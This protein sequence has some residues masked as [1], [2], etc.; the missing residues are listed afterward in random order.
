MDFASNL[1]RTD[2]HARLTQWI[3]KPP[4]VNDSAKWLLIDAGLLEQDGFIRLMKP[5]ENTH[6]HNVFKK[7]RFEV[8]GS[9]APHL[10]QIGQ[11]D[12]H[13]QSAFL[14][15]LLILCNGIPALAAMDACEGV[16]SLS[17]CLS[18]FAQ[19]FTPDN[20]E[21]YC[22]L[23]DTRI[24]PALLQVMDDEQRVKIGQNILQWQV[25][26]RLGTLEALLPNIKAQHKDETPFKKF[27]SG[28]SFTLSDKQFATLM[29]KSEPDTVFQSLLKD[30]P[31]LV[32]AADRGLFHQRL[33]TITERA[34]QRG[35]E[36]STD[37]VMFTIVALNTGDKFDAHPVLEETWES[38]K[39]KGA[40]FNKLVNAWPDKIWNE[41]AQAASA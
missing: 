11:L 20:L 25:V 23:A 19:A 12:H 28:K 15:D 39:Q 7:S 38:I 34:H 18:W 31:D 10:F 27:T 13:A 5:Y 35:I 22:R 33:E 29:Q 8:Y 9:Y 41:L 2:L 17:H 36:G 24:T 16:T 32:P 4:L 21:L 3:N 30:N 14:A 1:Y 6:L 37:M 40:S 26:N